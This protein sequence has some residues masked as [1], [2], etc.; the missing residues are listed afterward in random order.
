MNNYFKMPLFKFSRGLSMDQFEVARIIEQHFNVADEYS[1]TEIVESLKHQ[2]KPHTYD[3]KVVS[4]LEN[5]EEEVTKYNIL[6]SLK[7]LYRKLERNN[8]GKLYTHPMKVVLECINMSTDDDRLQKIMLDLKNYEWIPEVKTFLFSLTK[9]PL[10]RQNILTNNG[11]QAHPVYSIVESC[12]QGDIVY[13]HNKWFLFNEKN[14]MKEVGSMLEQLVDPEQM[15]R[16]NL[17]KEMMNRADIS[18]DKIS[19]RLDDSLTIGIGIEDK[20]I[21]LNDELVEKETTLESIFESPLV[22]YMQKGMYPIVL[23][24]YNSI[25]KFHQ[26]DNVTLITV[27]SRPDL[28]VY[29]VDLKENVYCYNCSR[30]GQHLYG[31]TAVTELLEDVQSETGFNISYMFEDR[32]PDEIRNIRELE[33][34]ERM[35]QLDIRECQEAIEEIQHNIN[36]M[37]VSPELNE[38]YDQLQIKKLDLEKQLKEVRFKKIKDRYNVSAS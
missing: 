16:M 27:H 12:D 25:D 13:L 30:L 9:T 2:L 18:D 1:E 33:D 10:E 5:M 23:E 15:Y 36:L 29:A 3:P 24:T 34:Q 31:Y 21:Y 32:L 14:E 37:E 6:Y 4:L 20:G 38:A 17:L 19:F 35:I 7:D 22:H 11:A 8:S 28:Y 26:M